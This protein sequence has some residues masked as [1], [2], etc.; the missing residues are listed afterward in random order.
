[1]LAHVDS[2]MGYLHHTCNAKSIVQRCFE[3][4]YVVVGRLVVVT[5][6]VPPA[7]PLPRS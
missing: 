2:M 7:K 3:S 1:M 4:L 5:R 6:P